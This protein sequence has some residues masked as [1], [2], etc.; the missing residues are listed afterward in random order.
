MKYQAT[1][2]FVGTWHKL[3]LM[4]FVLTDWPLTQAHVEKL[5][6]IKTITKPTNA[7]ISCILKI[8]MKLIYLVWSLIL[9]RSP[10]IFLKCHAVYHFDHHRNY[11]LDLLH[12]INYFNIFLHLSD[13][14]NFICYID[15]ILNF[16]FLFIHIF[17][18][19]RYLFYFRPC[20]VYGRKWKR[21]Q[22]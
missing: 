5:F 22:R 13:H 20:S 18:W 14:L 3:C 2:V 1:R 8:N 12:E 10:G 21:N 17:H 7:Y 19:F 6:I 16:L 4:F 11:F 9:S 15:E